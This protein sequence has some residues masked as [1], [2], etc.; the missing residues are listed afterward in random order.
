MRS[1]FLTLTLVF[2]LTACGKKGALYYPDMLVP[3]APTATSVSQIGNSVKLQFVLP[4]DDRVG[5]KLVDLAGVKIN[6]RVSESGQEQICISCV[7]DYH[8]F[9][10]LYLSL[11]TEGTYR[12]GNRI[13]VLDGDV[14]AG[15]SYSYSVVPF[16]KDG[17]DG[18]SSP[19]I[20]VSVVQPAGAPILEAES[21][22]TE[23][24]ISFVSLPPAVGRFL[25]YNI[26]RTK[27]K[28]T[29]PYQPV[30]REPLMGKYYIDS[31]LERN[32]RYLY[33]ARTVFEMKTGNVLESPVSNVVDGM[34]KDDE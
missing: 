12:Y 29:V 17:V 27:E 14:S 25:G 3:S 6:K 20:S 10:K 26:Y 28:D 33:M 22:P 31:G 15:K 24:R 30:N 23:I 19:Q 13:I 11:M 16:T 7:T 32:V 5:R 4:D 1:L 34:L 8:L 2:S 9:R 18:L 21:F